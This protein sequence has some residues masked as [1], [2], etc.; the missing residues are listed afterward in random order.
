MHVGKYMGTKVGL[1]FT[2]TDANSD[3]D[4]ISML[5]KFLNNGNIFPKYIEEVEDP[6]RISCTNC[7][8]GRKRIELCSV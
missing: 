2:E 1:G 5:H 4:Y 8:M 6:Q 3:I 7:R